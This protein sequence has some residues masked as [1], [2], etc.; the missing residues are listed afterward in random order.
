MHMMLEVS[1][2]S[3]SDRGHPVGAAA[4]EVWEEKVCR[5]ISPPLLVSDCRRLST[6]DVTQRHCYVYVI[7]IY[8]PVAVYVCSMVAVRVK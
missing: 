7:V 3:H 8:G 5:L 2:T 6:C 1:L 4:Q